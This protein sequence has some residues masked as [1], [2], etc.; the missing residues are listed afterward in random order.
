MSKRVR[1]P[2]RGH[3]VRLPFVD[4][5]I[6]AYNS[7]LFLPVQAPELGQYVYFFYNYNNMLRH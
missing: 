3:G 5:H 6:R 1:L 2:G 7:I 4:I